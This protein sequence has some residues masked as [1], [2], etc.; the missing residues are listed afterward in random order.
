MEGLE[1]HFDISLEDADS[2]RRQ[3]EEDS[4]IKVDMSEKN[5]SL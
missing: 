5:F 4:S 1:K 3:I 2:I